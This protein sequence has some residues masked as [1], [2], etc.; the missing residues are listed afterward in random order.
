MNMIFNSVYTI[1][2]TFLVFY[3]TINISIQIINMILL[4]CSQ[5]IFG[6]EDKMIQMLTIT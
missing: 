5:T 6:P 4:Y 3:D 2:M 1:Q